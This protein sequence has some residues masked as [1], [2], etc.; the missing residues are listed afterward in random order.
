MDYSQLSH[1][2]VDHKHK[3]LYCYVPKVCIKA[4]QLCALYLFFKNFQVACTN[5]KRVLMVLTEL[6]NATNLVNIP[7]STAHA[8]TL[9]LSLAYLNPNDT[10]YSLNNYITFLMVRHPF[11]RL[12][13][14]YRNKFEDSSP[15]AK[16]FQVIIKKSV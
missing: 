13:S 10:E 6:S 15:S 14:A 5:W 2:L 8:D 7:A 12:L 11:E 3:L 1:V 9:N 16:Y 4:R